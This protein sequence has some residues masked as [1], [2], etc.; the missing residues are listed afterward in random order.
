MPQNPK[1]TVS[2]TTKSLL[3][4][5]KRTESDTYENVILSLSPGTALIPQ[6]G[7]SIVGAGVGD[8]IFTGYSRVLNWVSDTEKKM[9]AGGDYEA[10]P[11]M[12]EQAYE[13][14]P[15][16]N[17]IIC[18]YL[19]NTL[20]G[21]YTIETEDNKKYENCITE[22]K[23]FVDDEIKLISVFREDFED[24]AI[25]H[26]YS[27]RRKDYH[28][29]YFDEQ[30]GGKLRQ[31]QRLEPKS[32]HSY[33]DPWDSSIKAHHQQIY[34]NDTWSTKGNLN[35]RECNSWFIPDGIKYIPGELE[36]DGAEEL[37]H[38][39][40]QK[41]NITDIA[42]LRVDSVD[43]IIAM[44]KVRPGNPAPIDAAILAI[45]LKRLMLANGPNYIFNVIMP[46]L[47]LKQGV[48]LKVPDGVGGEKLITSVPPIPPADMATTDPEKYTMMNAA[49]AAYTSA[50]KSNVE[51]ILRYRNEGG[52]FASSPDIELDV[53]ESARTIPAEFI[54][55]MIRLLDE[56]IARA[57]GF[58]LALISA[59]G[60]E[61]AT[62]RTILELFNTAYAGS[63][64]DYELVANELVK[65]RFAGQSWEYEVEQK[66]GIT[67]RGTFTFE[68]AAPS[69]KLVTGDVKDELKEAQVKLALMQ[70]LQT[71]KMLGASISDI[72]A[73]GDEYGFGVLELDRIDMLPPPSSMF[74][75]GEG[76][77][78]MMQGN[79][80]KDSSGNED[81]SGNKQTQTQS[82]MQSNKQDLK[83]EV[84]PKSEDELLKDELLKTYKDAQKDIV[85]LF[86]E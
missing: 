85:E 45:W 32:M 21:D 10:S 72:Q 65:E 17:G 59:N 79:D 37:W 67:E 16:V 8:D 66:G 81:S 42:G 15:L 6:N 39:Y 26:G 78:E 55:K 74:G 68:E 64:Q 44:H 71:A 4:S 24:Y 46:F 2:P 23:E 60:S 61:L 25:K 86:R 58:P 40:Q 5:L 83:P 31:L 53:T 62:S 33:E 1:I 29:S 7:N 18:P 47:H 54:E 80:N 51:N 50:L 69:F 3:D 19:K 56:D 77:Q 63:R 30:N 75:G 20:L 9:P 27:Y 48:M 76:R 36:P 22:I 38:K 52:I 84:I 35:T 73:L 34:V 82:T 70:T 57:F 28:D 43:K 49:R 14:D 12:R 13:I 41:Y 11:D